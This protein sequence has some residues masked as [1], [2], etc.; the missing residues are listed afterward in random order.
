MDAK[1]RQ[2]YL[3]TTIF[4]K[5][6][7]PFWGSAFALIL[8]L[9]YETNFI[10]E[11][12]RILFYVGGVFLAGLGA[13]LY[14]NLEETSAQDY[15]NKIRELEE[16]LERTDLGLKERIRIF[17]YI[18]SIV[19][20]KSVRFVRQCNK[21]KANPATKGDIFETITQPRDQIGKILEFL[22]LFFS[23][24]REDRVV[25]VL[26]LK[27]DIE[28]GHFRFFSY[29]PQGGR[30]STPAS[31]LKLT[32]GVA[33]SAYTK[34]STE[35]VEDIQADLAS[36]S[37]TYYVYDNTVPAPEGSIACYPIRDPERDMI[38]FILSVYINAPRVLKEDDKNHL[39][40]IFDPF[41][42]RILLE[43]RLRF[44]KEE[45]CAAGS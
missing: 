41:A 39:D 28:A 5:Y 16:E 13:L 10:S 7:L 25:K 23:H 21:L 32:R 45:C 2:W 34:G 14:K 44:L 19:R 27:P 26:L 3:N 35:I 38:A 1:F 22:G 30:P 37:P 20:E 11:N 9:I 31:E 33:G 18:Q 43:E 24:N 15:R 42:E 12:N 36:D 8:P 6:V 29:Y 4:R 17:S 40:E